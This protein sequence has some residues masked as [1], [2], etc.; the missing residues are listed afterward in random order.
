MVDRPSLA[1]RF[2]PRNNSLWTMR[3][4]LATIVAV[5]HASEIG[6]S[7]QPSLGNTLVGD[8]AVDGFFVIS[9]YLVTR[10]ALRLGSLRRFAW[11]RGLRIMPGFWICLMATAFIAAPLV[12]VQRSGSAASV[13][14]GAESAQSFVVN[15]AALLIR[16]WQIAGLP[17]EG[18]Q[19]MNGSL[20]TLFYEAVC[21][22]GVG[23]LLILGVI[24]Q[25][26]APGSATARVRRHALAAITLSAW[27]FLAAQVL[28]LL[29]GLFDYLPRF[30]LLFLLG[31]MGHVYGHRVRF[32]PVLVASAVV[33]LAVALTAFE[34]Y[35]LSGAVPF[36]YLVLWLMVALPVRREPS[37]D[38][39]YGMY[40]YHWPLALVLAGTGLVGDIGRAPFVL[41]CLTATTAVALASWYLVEGP[42]LRH[43]G[44]AWVERPL[45]R[46]RRTRSAPSAVDPAGSAAPADRT[47]VLPEPTEGSVR[48]G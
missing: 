40:V 5:V 26:T 18:A 21:Y 11:H 25:P 36:A 27:A 35:R 2:D 4:S 44:A 28:G 39:S 7:W 14:S 8:L 15:N 23:V 45:P 43:K 46:P 31:A 38:L 13:F 47:I 41:A 10:S 16:Q 24:G 22:L 1:T 20:W 29:G 30:S 48:P 12:A 34:E 19:A 17:D 37:V 9:G 3:L 6:W 42:S 33:L 32:S